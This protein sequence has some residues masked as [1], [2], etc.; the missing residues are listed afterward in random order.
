MAEPDLLVTFTGPDRPGQA[1]RLLA[2]MAQLGW[3]ILDVEQ[4][5]I[6]RRLLLGVL[7][8]GGD[9]SDSARRS[10]ADVAQDIGLAT[11]FEDIRPDTTP[12]R[13]APPR[14]LPLNQGR[15]LVTLLGAELG[16]QVLGSVADAIGA[17]GANIDRIVRLSDYPVFS[18]Q[19]DVSGAEAE[20]LRAV[21]GT[22]AARLQ[23]DVAVQT[24]GLHHRAQRLV[25]LDVDSTLIQGE[26]VELLAE[27][28]GVGPEV[29]RITHEAM[30]GHLDFEEALRARVALLAG[31]DAAVIDHV[32]DH[33]QLTPGARTLIRTLKRL[34]YATAIVSGGFTQVT[35]D[36]VAGLGIDY[37]AANTLEIRHGVLTGGLVGAVVDRAGKAEALER[38][39]QEAGVPLSLTVAVGDGANDLDMLA[40][41][42]LGIAF[43]AKSIVRAAADT[44]VSVPYLDAILFLLGIPRD[45]I[46][47]ADATDSDARAPD[48]R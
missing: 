46:E 6:R 32:R 38:F 26:V 12:P 24:S 30:A 48:A 42:G 5:S 43:N 13:P 8:G 35:D 47:Q 44:S 10:L 28:A 3:A 15:L 45:E 18:Y 34:G 41:A 11:E 19:F 33:L 39:A 1:G 25:V 40:R 2:R 9:V 4:V 23:I 22:E 20:S 16:P 14:S 7:V 36:L 37:A 27:H 29:E 17:S 31:L 21:L